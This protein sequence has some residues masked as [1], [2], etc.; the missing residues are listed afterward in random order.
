MKIFALIAPA[1]LCAALAACS[2]M[3]TQVLCP[4]RASPAVLV[5]V[6]DPSSNLSVS[7]EASGTWS[8]GT[9]TDSL[10]HVPNPASGEIMLAAYGP[11]GVY[12]VRVARPGHADWIRGG[13]Q[14]AQ[15]VCGPASAELTAQHAAG[16]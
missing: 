6:V 2:D 16:E 10:V 4:D 5:N 11:P 1:L 9:R 3:T 14:V 8:S 15:G 13:I 7:A 12:D